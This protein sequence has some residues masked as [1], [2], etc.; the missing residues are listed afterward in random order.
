[1]D[2]FTK[3]LP[4]SHSKFPD[5]SPKSKAYKYSVLNLRC[6]QEGKTI[7]Q[8]RIFGCLEKHTTSVY[9]LHVLATL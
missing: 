9:L 5:F 2:P 7:S 6:V 4:Y 1:M 3:Q 8:G